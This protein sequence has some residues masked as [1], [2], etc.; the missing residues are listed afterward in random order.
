[1]LKLPFDTLKVTFSQRCHKGVRQTDQQTP[2]RLEL[3]RAA[4]NQTFPTI[5]LHQPQ[6]TKSSR[7]KTMLLYQ[8]SVIRSGSTLASTQYSYLLHVLHIRNI[9]ILT[10]TSVYF[11]CGW[12]RGGRD[13]AWPDRDSPS[14]PAQALVGN[15]C[16]T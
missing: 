10:P 15:I 1:M 5:S 8:S 16:H 6:L 14:H 9:I 4:K 11:E 13:P 12:G 7:L 2:R 3:L